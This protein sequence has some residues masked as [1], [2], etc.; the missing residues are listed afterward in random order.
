VREAQNVIKRKIGMETRESVHQVGGMEHVALHQRKK[1]FS[2][3]QAF[4]LI[5]FKTKSI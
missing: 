2:C 3:S 4:N 5:Q 1:N